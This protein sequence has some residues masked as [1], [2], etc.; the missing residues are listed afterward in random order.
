MTMNSFCKDKAT[1]QGN[2]VEPRRD[3]GGSLDR[4]YQIVS[5]VLS[6]AQVRG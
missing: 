2:G 1:A 4:R 6:P 3:R 5:L